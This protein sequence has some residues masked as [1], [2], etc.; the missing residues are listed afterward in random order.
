MRAR[1]RQVRSL[2]DAAS[3]SLVL[4]RLELAGARASASSL[5]AAAAALQPEHKA[6]PSGAH[7]WEAVPDRTPLH[8]SSPRVG[9]ARAVHG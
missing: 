9:G 2:R 6:P 1:A 5:A 3:R 4:R 8:L 7:L